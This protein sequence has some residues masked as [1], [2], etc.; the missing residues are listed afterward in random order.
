METSPPSP[1][2]ESPGRLPETP[3]SGQPARPRVV[4][5]GGG[6]GGVGAARQ[7]KKADAD[8]VLLDEH[9]YHTFQP[10]LY[11]VATGL[12]DGSTVGHPLRD[13]FHDQGNVTVHQAKVTGIDL[14]GRQVQCA[15]MAPLSYD[16]LVLALGARVNFFGVEGAAEHAFPLYTL[17]DAERLKAHILHQWEQADRDRSLV[18]DGA[19]N[20]VVVGGGPTG[21]ESAGALAELYRGNFAADYPQLPEEQAKI[22][23]VEAGPALFSMFKPELRA[24]T[25]KALEKRGVE[26]LLGEVVASV[27]PTRVT[28]KSGRVL[29]AHTLVWGAGLQAHPITQTLGLPLEKGYRVGVEADLGVAGHEGVF[30][31]G[32][33]AWITDTKTKQVLPQLGSVALQSGEHAGENIA[34]RIAG[35][36]TEPFAYVDK[37][38]MATIGRGAGVVQLPRGR[39]MK[40]KAASLAWGAVHLALLSTGEDRAKSIVNWTWAGFTHER[41]GRM[42]VATDET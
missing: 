28:F 6:F 18:D 33:I 9:D 22:T 23:L 42:T 35:R 7:L 34:R 29:R 16:Y 31:S 39:T 26:V 11:Q 36:P 30:A 13:L 4:I 40:G 19:L 8:V 21:V 10:L 20:V 41:A 32:D 12:L 2:A 15:D 24:Y 14:A 17:A 37:G 3:G 5:L 1:P 27:T 25:K 38:T